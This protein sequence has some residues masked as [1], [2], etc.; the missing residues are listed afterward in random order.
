MTGVRAAVAEYI[1]EHRDEWSRILLSTYVLAQKDRIGQYGSEYRDGL[2]ALWGHSYVRTYYTWANSPPPERALMEGGIATT[3]YVVKA[4]G[5]LLHRAGAAWNKSILDEI[6][7]FF[8]VRTTPAG[9][10]VLTMD[11]RGVPKIATHPRHTCYGYLIMVGLVDTPGAPPELNKLV[12]MCASTIVR[13]VAKDVLLREWIIESWPVGCIASY[14]ASR[15]HIYNSPYARVWAPRERRCWPGVREKLL[16]ALAQLSSTQLSLLG[17]TKEKGRKG[18]DEHL[19]YWHPIKDAVELRLHSTLGCLSLVGKDLAARKAGRGRIEEIVRD[20]RRQLADDPEHS[21]RFS[22]DRPPSI[23]AAC[24]ML[25]LILGEW[26]EPAADDRALVFEV[27]DF[28]RTRWKDSELYQD[29]WT[30]FTAPLLQIN[31]MFAGLDASGFVRRGER[32]LS[33]LET[34]TEGARP[35]SGDEDGDLLDVLTRLTPVALGTP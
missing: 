5:T 20:V 30:E 11:P 34:T 32:I 2:P 28:I 33:L 29:Y 35:H 7:D 12:E 4:L 3:H 1:S 13:P 26:Y 16:D 10:G 8:V 9:V 17:A 6:A 14:I 21:P 31:E 18:F 23:S 19:P 15:D 25:K 22:P 27:L 24:A